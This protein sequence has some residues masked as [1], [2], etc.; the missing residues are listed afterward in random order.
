MFSGAKPKS[1]KAARDGYEMK[2]LRVKVKKIYKK[3]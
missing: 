1:S 2:C 3:A